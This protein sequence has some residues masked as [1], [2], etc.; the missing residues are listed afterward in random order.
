LSLSDKF[1]T[2]LFSE[3]SLGIV[4]PIL[5]GILIIAFP[6]VLYDLF[7][8]INIYFPGG[9]WGGPEIPLEHI[10][11]QGIAQGMLGCGI[12]IF[13]GLVWN[14]WAGGASGFLLSTLWV[15]ASLA[16]FGDW[17]YP[18]VDWLGLVIAGM[19]AGYIAGSLK[20][21]ALMRGSDRLKDVLIAVIVAAIVAIIFTTATYVWYSPMF[22]ISTLPPHGTGTIEGGGLELW[23]SIT[24]S[25]FINSAIYIVWAIIAAFMSRVASW[26]Q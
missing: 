21:R 17:F 4:I 6:T 10:L 8:P 2:L 7:E 19:L 3:L 24:Y 13:I 23:D 26:F 5:L 11:T 12:P 22:Q 15:M 9:L 1:Y 25:Y 18:T 14:R 16:Q 20:T